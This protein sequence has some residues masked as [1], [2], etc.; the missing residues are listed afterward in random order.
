MLGIGE[1]S[2]SSTI[3]VGSGSVRESERGACAYANIG[4]NLIPTIILEALESCRASSIGKQQNVRARSPACRLQAQSHKRKE[5][6]YLFIKVDYA[7][8][9]RAHR[10][11]S[12]HRRRRR[13]LVLIP[14]GW[15]VQYT[16][17]L[18]ASMCFLRSH[19]IATIEFE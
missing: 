8:C 17:T 5:K 3:A 12:R 6:K 11:C 4:Y 15:A 13:R 14:S 18:A 16:R 1:A 9:E 10:S 2:S 19:R 7:M